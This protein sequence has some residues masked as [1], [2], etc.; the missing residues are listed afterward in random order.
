MKTSIC[1]VTHHKPYFIMASLISL[2]LQKFDDYDLHIIF[3]EGDGSEKKY[4]K[5]ERLS[6]KFRK[7]SKFFSE[8]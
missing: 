6:K 1:I 7:N 4:P 2:A 3:I 5:Y 8:I